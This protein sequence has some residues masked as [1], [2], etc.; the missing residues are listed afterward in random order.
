MGIKINWTIKTYWKPL[1]YHQLFCLI[2]ICHA[3]SSVFGIVPYGYSKELKERSDT[4]PN[5]FSDNHSDLTG[6]R[7]KFEAANLFVMHRLPETKKEWLSYRTNLFNEITLKTGFTTNHQLPLNLNETGVNQMAGYS[8]RNIYFQTRPGVY[9]TANLYIPDG[10]GKFPAVIVMMGHAQTG[11]LDD[12]YQSLGHSLA[13]NGYVAL[14]IDPWGSGERTTVHGVFE[15]HGDE[16]NLGSSLMNIGE[17]LMGIE[18]SDNIRGVDLLCSLPYVDS[19]NI[20]ATGSSG[21]GNQTMWL[22]ALDNRIKAAVPVV[23]AGTFES[24]IL[25][26]PCICEVLINGLNL[27]EEAGILSLIAPRAVKMC[28]HQKDNNQAFRPAETIRSYKNAKPVFELYGAG[29]NISYQ[30]FDLPHGYFPEDR[31]VM[32]GWF[33]KYLKGSGNGIPKKEVPFELLPK[34]KLMVFPKSERDS[35]VISTAN[36]CKL[37]GNQ[38]RADFLNTKSFNTDV[39][40]GQLHRILGHKSEISLK[41]INELPICDGWNRIA[42][43]TSDNKIIPVLV[44]QPSGN[45]REF[46]IVCNTGGK[47]MIPKTLIDKLISSGKGIA[48]VD[49]SGTGEVVS[50]PNSSDRNGNLLTLSRSLLWFGKTVIGEW[51]N[52]FKALS[53]FLRSNYHASKIGIDANKEAGVAAL[54][55][56]ALEGSTDNIIVRNA[57]VSYLFDTPENIDFFSMGVNLPGFLNWGDISLVASMN[58]SNITFIDPVTMS[59]RKISGINL[60]TFSIEFKKIRSL[61][62]ISGETIFIETEQKGEAKHN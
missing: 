43:E 21:G 45:S 6:C 49:L 34:E 56:S 26:T 61:T 53:D 29:D 7:L 27:T 17:T 40:R 57:P 19:L 47:R 11:R 23:S 31:E 38:L 35:K 50:N 54:I 41:S 33:D 46:T 25:G 14:C 8:I 52:E 28:N 18:I 24:Y 62:N 36:W 15:D 37:K 22:T 39:K 60:D 20:G 30:L 2:A 13:L 9:A 12:R 59:G 58:R 16:N 3:S 51:V 32:L 1:R 55:F 5:V 4:L 42:L 10:K 48:I 44:R